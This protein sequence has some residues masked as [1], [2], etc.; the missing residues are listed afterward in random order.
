MHRLPVERVIA[1]RTLPIVFTGL[2]LATPSICAAQQMSPEAKSVLAVIRYRTTWLRDTTAYSV[3]ALRA[4]LPTKDSTAT[5]SLLQNVRVPLHGGPSCGP[6][7]QA[8]SPARD[9][10]TVLRIS[11]D[12][13]TGT[14]RLRVRHGDYSHEEEY[15]VRSTRLP[16]ASWYVLEGRLS[17][18][19]EE[20]GKP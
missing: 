8:S 1:L 3:C 7:A 16:A 10:V 9:L 18:G 14:V 5:T 13:S 6:G 15:R 2:M 12:D 4:A 17:G 20:V 11:A 19:L